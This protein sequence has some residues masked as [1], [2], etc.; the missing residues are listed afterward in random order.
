M[1]PPAIAEHYVHVQDESKE[2]AAELTETSA[3][4]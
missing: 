4:E 2:R 1:L 3:A